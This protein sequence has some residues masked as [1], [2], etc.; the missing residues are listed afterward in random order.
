LIKRLLLSIFKYLIF[1]SI[2]FLLLWLVFRKVDLQNVA[3]QFANAN[4]WWILLSFVFSICSHF[5]RAARWNILIDNMGYKTRLTTT[6]YA[7]MTGYLANLALPRLGEITRCG[8]LSQK[9]K[10]PVNTLFGS[11][12]A[13]RVFDTLVLLVLIFLVVIFQM[14]LVGRFLEEHIFTP[15]YLRFEDSMSLIVYS[16]LGFVFFLILAIMLIRLFLHK[17]KDKAFYKKFNDFVLGFLNGI[18]TIWKLKKKGPF[19]ILT[20]IIWLMYLMMS[21]VVFFAM[22]ATSGLTLIDGLTV[23]AI[24][25]LGMVAPVPGGIGAY[26]F[27]VTMIL[28]ELYAIPKDAAASW[29]TLMH[30]SQSLLII[31]IGAFSYLMLF[32][33]QKKVDHEKPAD[34]PI[35]NI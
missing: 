25:S 34:Y 11:V 24:G 15:V 32:L 13:E 1:L 18:Q 21:F 27:F 30:A 33:Q 10:I 12:V 14:E 28:F 7:V 35:Q 16:F 9:D 2:G 17:I 31:A 5:A 19:L 29:A 8:A 3:T 4:Y 26:H 20:L 6:F 23:L 22:Q